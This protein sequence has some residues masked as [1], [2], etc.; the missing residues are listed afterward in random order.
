MSIKSLISNVANTSLAPRPNAEAGQQGLTA[1]NIRKALT[2]KNT[3]VFKDYSTIPQPDQTSANLKEPLPPVQRE[4]GPQPTRQKVLAV[5]ENFDQASLPNHHSTYPSV[6]IHQDQSIPTSTVHAAVEA[7]FNKIHL[8][9]RRSREISTITY[10]DHNVKEN[11]QKSCNISK[12]ESPVI[13]AGQTIYILEDV[14]ASAA[15]CGPKPDLSSKSVL[16]PQSDPEE[17]W[18]EEEDEKDNYDEEGYVTA[19]SFRSMGENITG[20]ATTTLVPRVN[21]KARKEI[22]A[23]KLL[24]ESTK[25]P[26]DIEDDYWDTSMVNEYG[27]EI[28]GYMHELEV[29]IP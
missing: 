14:D 3:T 10:V 24:I 4:I 23:A 19:R 25:T 1:A 17:C 7:K 27:D 5:H 2:K 18:D 26:E 28:F 21:A 16:Q 6:T 9:E 29:Y 15:S 13:P 22:A 12:D 20:N 8:E 11:L